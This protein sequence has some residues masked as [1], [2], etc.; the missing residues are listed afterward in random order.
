MYDRKVKTRIK[1]LNEHKIYK[2]QT[3][4]YKVW[5]SH[6]DLFLFLLIIR[7]WWWMSWS[8]FWRNCRFFL[9]ITTFSLT[10]TPII[11][12]IIQFFSISY[13]EENKCMSILE[14]KFYLPRLASSSSS[15]QLLPDSSSD[16]KFS[17]SSK[18]SN[19]PFP[20]VLY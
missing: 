20:F 19:F 4:N 7:W 8:F 16:P 5:Y 3:I 9:R 14:T 11:R 17:D 2:K 12:I 10:T 18:R 15:L 1:C 13:K 6:S